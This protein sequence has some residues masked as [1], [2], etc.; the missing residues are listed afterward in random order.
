MNVLL[1]WAVKTRVSNEQQ[2]SVRAGSCRSFSPCST[3]EMYL[4]LITLKVVAASKAAHTSIR[5]R[6]DSVYLAPEPSS[7]P[8][9][10]VR[11]RW[12]RFPSVP[13]FC[14]CDT[15]RKE[16]VCIFFQSTFLKNKKVYKLIHSPRLLNLL[17]R[18]KQIG[19]SRQMRAR[20]AKVDRWKCGTDIHVSPTFAAL[21]F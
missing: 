7:Q 3:A 17:T 6:I 2:S 9:L 20:S 21:Q 11:V 12:A 4:S 10:L 19:R 18:F 5:H 13:S 1:F 15:H 8:A 16:V 14:A